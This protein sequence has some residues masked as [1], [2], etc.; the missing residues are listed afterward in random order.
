MQMTGKDLRDWRDRFGLSQK[1]AA[2]AIGCSTRFIQTRE[3]EP[4][5]PCPGWLAMA[6]RG[7]MATGRLARRAA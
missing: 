4:D 1:A 7:V 3:A 6:I 2:A 5:K